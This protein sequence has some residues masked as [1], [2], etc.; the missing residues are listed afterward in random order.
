VRVRLPRVDNLDLNLFEFDYDLTFMVFFLNSQE[1]VYARYGGRDAENPDRRQSLAGLRYTMSSVLAMHERPDKQFAPRAASAPKYI[2]D[3]PDMGRRGRCLHCH[4]VK[5][6]LNNDLQRTGKWDRD[7]VWRFPLPENLG[8][9]LEVDRGNV[10]KQVQA[11]SP[12]DQGGLGA[13]GILERLGKVPIHSFADAQLALDRAPRTGSLE[14]AWRHGDEVHIGKLLLSEGWRKGDI[15]WRPSMQ[16][17]IPAARLYGV[18]LTAMEKHALQ[19]APKQLAFRQKELVP[20]QARDAGVKPGDIIVGINGLILEMNADRFLEYVRQH[21]LV[22][23]RVTVNLI[24]D[25]KRLELPM[26]LRR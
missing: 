20:A 14:V 10:I 26:Q 9:E 16:R 5:Q 17:L 8:L 11:Q 6:I 3:V 13:G 21:F 18:D 25:G 23:D 7:M 19:L 12:A 22:G 2:R 24:R 4:Q 15:T 1:Q